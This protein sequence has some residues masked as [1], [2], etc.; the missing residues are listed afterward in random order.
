MS[1]RR[2]KKSRHPWP[3]PRRTAANK[4][5]RAAAPT[6]APAPEATG[7]EPEFVVDGPRRLSEAL[8][9]KLQRSFYAQAGPKAWKPKGVPSFITNNAFIARAYARMALAYLR[10]L[11]RAGALLPGQPLHVLELAGG[12]GRFAFLFLRALEE[13]RRHLPELAAVPVRYVLTDLVQSNL[14][15]ARQ[16]ERLKPFV[17]DGRF[18]VAHLDLE[19]DREIT[20][21]VSGRRVGAGA[22]DSATLVLANYAFDSIPCDVFGVRD[23]VL[24][25]ALA[26]LVSTRR[27]ET[28]EDPM[29]LERLKLRWEAVPL[30]AADPYEDP[31]IN[32]VLKGY[33]HL[34]DTN[35]VMPV[36]ALRVL[37]RLL[38][39]TGGR[40][41]L[42]SGDKCFSMESEMANRAEPVLVTHGG[43]FSFTV[44]FHTLG[45]Y[46]KARGG[47][48]LLP[49]RGDYNF[50]VAAFLCGL[51][52]APESR[53]AYE[54]EIDSFG[55]GE[56]FHLS[57]TLR[58]QISDLSLDTLLSAFKLGDWDP[59]MVVGCRKLV[60]RQARDA[61]PWMKQE[62]GQGVELCWERVFPLHR[63]L[64]MELAW[65]AIAVG[66]PRL[67]IHLG[68]ESQRLWGATA[69]GYSV[70]GLGHAQ[71]GET[72]AAI[73]NAERAL[74][75]EP[76][77]PA[78][79]KLKLAALEAA[80][81][82]P[83]P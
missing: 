43:C 81:A 52:D 59:E 15:Y 82:K 48:A 19:H 23:H 35:F 34:G 56:Y 79:T 17:D 83:S 63:N 72:D 28:L 46:V 6:A 61:K 66:R 13:E 53:L 1:K 5:A 49:R 4:G 33:T 62:L 76:D 70:I 51:A 68:R 29:L 75:L 2:G 58:R 38:E 12:M 77:N 27:E 21:Q 50:K 69:L 7:A 14:D 44:N 45:E 30:R 42:L 47:Q 60:T 40:M 37:G 8:I 57:Y 31:I 26:T 41:M 3:S 32:Q 11:L 65:I 10:D 20:L 22:L 18:D 78:G 67:A 55:P 73:E 64:A 54:R 9:W 80:K 36:G 74:A 39:W 71:L 16:H 25:E 24:Q